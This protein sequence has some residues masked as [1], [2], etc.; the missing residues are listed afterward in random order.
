M[1]AHIDA[2]AEKRAQ[3]KD[4]IAAESARPA[5]NF[6]LITTLKKQNLTLKEEMQRYLILMKKESMSA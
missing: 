6:T 4:Q 5:P 2:I 1:K 3:L